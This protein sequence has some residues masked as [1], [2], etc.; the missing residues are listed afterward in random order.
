MAIP[1]PALEGQSSGRPWG[2]WRRQLLAAMRLELRKSFL[3][4]R[5]IGLLILALMPVFIL[6]I[7]AVVPG[8]VEDP[9]TL[10]DATKEP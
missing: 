6:T 4:K 1:I 3:G 2:L 10:A 8:V 5:A 9:S 7:R